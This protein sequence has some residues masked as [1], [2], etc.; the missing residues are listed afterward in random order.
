MSACDT[1]PKLAIENYEKSITLNP[2]N[3][4]GKEMLKRL[5]THSSH[6]E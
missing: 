2:N 3:T 6:I 4:D 1:S 5:L